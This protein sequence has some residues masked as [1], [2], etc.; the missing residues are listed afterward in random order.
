MA[1]SLHCFSEASSRPLGFSPLPRRNEQHE[2]LA[3]AEL[4]TRKF[5]TALPRAREIA[6]ESNSGSGCSP[7]VPDRSLD[8]RT[9]SAPR[10]LHEPQAL[11][12]AAAE[13][14]PDANGAF[15][16][17][18]KEV[19]SG[20][21][22]VPR[23]SRS[24]PH[25]EDKRREKTPRQDAGNLVHDDQ[26]K[27]VA[28]RKVTRFRRQD[29]PYRSHGAWYRQPSR[30]NRTPGS[31]FADWPIRPHWALADAGDRDFAQPERDAEYE[32]EE[33]AESAQHQASHDTPISEK[34]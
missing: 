8:T 1:P 5:S 13:W 27:P 24:A 10:C 2:A 34:R 26:C 6:A 14:K 7:G 25:G 11:E 20:W 21:A 31:G 28:F 33:H 22:S 18:Q 29:A 32:T 16:V 23:F 15:R 4:S 9:T 30:S 3:R 17:A 19:A 12:A